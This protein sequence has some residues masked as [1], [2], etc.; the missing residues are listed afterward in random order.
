MRNTVTDRALWGCAQLLAG[1]LLAMDLDLRF[2][3][4]AFGWLVE[5]GTRCQEE[6]LNLAPRRRTGA[7]VDTRR[8]DTLLVG[9]VRTCVHGTLGSRQLTVHFAVGVFTD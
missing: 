7:D 2:V 9:E 8:I 3:D 6:G 5:D 4:L 1:V